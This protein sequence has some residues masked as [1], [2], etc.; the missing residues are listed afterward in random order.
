MAKVKDLTGQKFKRLTV[1]S[2]S[3]NVSASGQIKWLCLCDC[4]KELEVIGNSLKT[5]NS[6]SCGCWNMDNITKH[7]GSYTLLYGVWKGMRAR[8][9]NENE[10]AYKHYGGR[11][12][13]VCDRWQT[14]DNFRKD[15]GE[16]FRSGLTLDRIDVNGNYEPGNCRWA[17]RKEQNNNMRKNIFLDSPWGRLTISQVADK[18]GITRVGLGLRLKRNWPVDKLFI[19]SKRLTSC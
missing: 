4:G 13:I 18:I 19:P 7:G 11:G 5:G 14:F 2:R 10:K 16:S 6:K 12:I 15:M 9:G 1:I 17:T 3:K 8:C